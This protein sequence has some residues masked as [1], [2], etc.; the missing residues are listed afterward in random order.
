MEDC[1]RKYRVAEVKS[2]P[3]LHANIEI[4]RLSDRVP[5]SKPV[6]LGATDTLKIIVT[7]TEDGTP[8]RPHQAFLMLKDLDTGLEESFPFSM[9]ESGKGKVDFVCGRTSLLIAHMADPTVVA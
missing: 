2:L 3:K 1:C 6:T 4:I 5:L 9:K 7:A 8:K